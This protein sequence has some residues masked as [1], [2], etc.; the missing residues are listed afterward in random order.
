MAKEG[1]SAEAPA[2][3]AT[4]HP[5]L[6]PR[7]HPASLHPDRP[8]APHLLQQRGGTETL[9][10]RGSPNTLP[11]PGPQALALCSSGPT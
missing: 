11:G 2:A 5:G 8:T 7:T 1:K 10:R 4:P 6:D 9:L 3:L